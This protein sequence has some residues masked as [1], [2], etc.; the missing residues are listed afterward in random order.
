MQTHQTGRLQMECAKTKM[1]RYYLAGH[2]KKAE[3]CQFAHNAGELKEIPDLQFTKMCPTLGRE[4]ACNNVACKFAH[5]KQQLRKVH[6]ASKRNR[7]CR[8]DLVAAESVAISIMQALDQP[9]R[10][11]QDFFSMSMLERIADGSSNF[12][13][14]STACTLS[15]LPRLGADDTESLSS[16]NSAW[17]DNSA[18][19]VESR[20]ECEHDE[21][22]LPRRATRNK[23]HKTKMCTFFLVGRC[24][25]R[26][27]CNFAHSEQELSDPPNL[28]CTKMCPAVLAGEV[29][30]SDD[31]SFAHCES[32]LRPSPLPPNQLACEGT[33]GGSRQNH[34]RSSGQDATLGSSAGY[35]S[36]GSGKVGLSVSQAGGHMPGGDG[37]LDVSGGSFQAQVGFQCTRAMS[38]VSWM[39]QCPML[40]NIGK[41]TQ[42]NCNFSHHVEL[43]DKP[44]PICQTAPRSPLTQIRGTFPAIEEPRGPQSPLRKKSIVESWAESSSSSDRGSE[45]PM[46]GSMG[47]DSDEDEVVSRRMLGEAFTTDIS[48]SDDQSSEDS[49]SDEDEL[50]EGEKA[51]VRVK[52]ASLLRRRSKRSI[53][54]CVKNTFFEHRGRARLA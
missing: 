1:C 40:V 4:G 21:A 36:G 35:H 44:L 24:R 52:S 10:Q 48:D 30:A 12:S 51:V 6:L 19:S 16:P 50:D 25:K 31:C 17:F 37:I 2:C 46:M 34:V 15:D 28:R 43:S 39:P 7:A 53:T 22:T 13:R 38:V 54:L 41:C 3:S 47:D 18:S 42:T 45:Y 23:F 29:C 26:G 5:D 9:K 33:E 11:L 20:D 49:G 14:Q 8:K 32:E 27:S